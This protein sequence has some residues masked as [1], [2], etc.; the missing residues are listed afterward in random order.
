MWLVHTLN[1]NTYMGYVLAPMGEHKSGIEVAK[2]CDIAR[3]LNGRLLSIISKNCQHT[4]VCGFRQSGSNSFNLH[5]MVDGR[6][7]APVDMINIPLFRG[8]H[9]CWVVQ[10]FFHQQYITCLDLFIHF[11]SMLICKNTPANIYTWDH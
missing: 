4:L 9:I 7:P 3:F 11:Y 1:A 6:N 10:D 5:D 2:M 8:F